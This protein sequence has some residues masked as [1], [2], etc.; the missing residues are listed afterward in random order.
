MTLLNLGSGISHYLN[1]F[2]PRLFCN[3]PLKLLQ[4]YLNFQKNVVISSCDVFLIT[5]SF[6]EEMYLKKMTF[7]NN[8]KGSLE[9]ASTAYEI[10]LFTCL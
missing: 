2:N 5:L 10:I 3:L 8:Q 1:E 4:S 9:N 7:K 6:Q